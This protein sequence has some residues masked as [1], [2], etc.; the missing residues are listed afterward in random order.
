[1]TFKRTKHDISH[2]ILHGTACPLCISSTAHY[3]QSVDVGAWVQCWFQ[4][5]RCKH[6]F[7]R[8]YSRRNLVGVDLNASHR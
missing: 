7:F 3:T 1:M 5:K 6:S 8:L 4:C 2:E